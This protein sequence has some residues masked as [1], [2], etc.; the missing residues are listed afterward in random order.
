MGNA[1][2]ISA[3]YAIYKTMNIIDIDISPSSTLVWKNLPLSSPPF[4]WRL[5]WKLDPILLLNEDEALYESYALALEEFSQSVLVPYKEKTQN[6]FFFEQD[7][8]LFLA[9]TP[10]LSPLELTHILAHFLHRLAAILPEDIP[11]MCSLS[12]SHIHSPSYLAT[13]FAPHRFSSFTLHNPKKLVKKAVLLPE[14]QKLSLPLFSFLDQII[15]QQGGKEALRLIC[16]ESLTECWDE[17]DVLFVLRE[18]VCPKT[19]RKL[20]GFQAAGGEVVF[21]EIEG[22]KIRSRGI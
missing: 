21:Y 10:T 14:E 18:I 2:K 3:F 12:F 1:R 22:E 6:L 8:S 9:C 17:L 16:E 19:A 11:L 13:L 5:Q 7:L 4:S 15:E 20:Q